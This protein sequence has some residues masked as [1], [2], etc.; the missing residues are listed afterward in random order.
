MVKNVGFL[1]IL[2][3]ISSRGYGNLLSLQTDSPSSS[4]ALVKPLKPRRVTVKKCRG[5]RTS[6]RRPHDREAPGVG[7][8]RM[9]DS[10]PPSPSA[11]RLRESP[12]ELL[13]CEG[14]PS[15]WVSQGE[16]VCGQAADLTDAFLHRMGA[17]PS[18]RI[19]TTWTMAMKLSRPALYPGGWNMWGKEYCG[20]AQCSLFAGGNTLCVCSPQ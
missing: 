11:L 6:R 2:G 9:R 12:A 15:F 10:S 3:Q 18:M 5:V 17:T 1:R 14:A 7:C 8:G 20:F 13:S 19:A 16:A 4:P